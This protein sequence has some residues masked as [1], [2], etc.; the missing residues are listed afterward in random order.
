MSPGWMAAPS[1][2]VLGPH[3]TCILG[4]FAALPPVATASVCCVTLDPKALHQQH[5]KQDGTGAECETNSE[6]V[7]ETD[8]DGIFGNSFPKLKKK[9]FPKMTEN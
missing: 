6:E 1:H 5:W 3:T 8:A 7:L 4:G 2:Q 9:G